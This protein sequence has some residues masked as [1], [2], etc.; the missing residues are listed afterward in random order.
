[1]STAPTF[2]TIPP[3]VRLLI[4][5]H[6]LHAHLPEAEAFFPQPAYS[7]YLSGTSP[8]TRHV[9]DRA[10]PPY[11]SPWALLRLC[12]LVRR[13]LQPL[14]AGAE[15]DGRLVFEFQAFTVRDMRAWAAAAGAAR[16]AAMRRWS[17]DVIIDCGAA[18]LG[19][20]PDDDDDG[21]VSES[22]GEGERAEVARGLERMTRLYERRHGGGEEGEESWEGG[23]GEESDDYDDEFGCYEK[24]HGVSLNV[25]LK[26]LG[27]GDAGGSGGSGDVDS[28]LDGSERVHEWYW[29][30][31]W[32]DRCE[33]CKD[34]SSQGAYWFVRD[35]LLQG[36]ER[37]RA[38][39]GELLCSMLDSLSRKARNTKERRKD[40]AMFRHRVH[41]FGVLD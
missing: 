40:W 41:E 8:F 29:G 17:L 27:P 22:E 5:Q 1:M 21:G 28:D 7:L 38:I 33:G 26:R 34:A 30:A 31:D 13:E 11:H 18:D 3:E 19:R 20:G 2:T 4:Y 14:L 37:P 36:E 35:E 9:A 6:V 16:V 15:A 39:T 32:D 24:F 25:D 12:R 23:T 10:A